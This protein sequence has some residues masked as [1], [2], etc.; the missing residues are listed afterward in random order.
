MDDR[1][2]NIF[3]FL[4]EKEQ[5]RPIILSDITHSYF[6][7]VVFSLLDAVGREMDKGVDNPSILRVGNYNITV[8][9]AEQSLIQLED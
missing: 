3:N 8:E 4:A 7:T 2:T 6:N 1:L 9:E 5:Q